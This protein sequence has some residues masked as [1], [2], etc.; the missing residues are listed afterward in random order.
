M[1]TQNHNIHDVRAFWEGNPL[2]SGE[3]RFPVGSREFFEEHSK[4]IIADCFAGRVDERIYPSGDNK[5]DVLDLGCGPG[6]WVVSLA[7]HGA[8]KITGADLTEKAL[9]LARCRCEVYNIDATLRQENAENLTFPDESFTHVNCQGVIHHTPNTERCV[10]EIARVLKPG[11]SAT[12]SVYFRH[13]LLRSWP[14][15]RPFGSALSMIGGGLKGRGREKIFSLRDPDDIVRIYD[16]ASNPIGKAYS[17]KQF[18]GM[19]EKYLQVEDV[20]YHFFPARSLPFKTPAIAH[21]FLDRN[22]GFMIFIRGKKR[23]N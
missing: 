7:Q 13:F 14:I 15:I 11:G 21:R 3:S 18:V 4:T 10:A 22:F 9:E 2:F 8:K 5:A 19:T 23:I 1:E 20:F 6:F 17:R 12:I 16:G